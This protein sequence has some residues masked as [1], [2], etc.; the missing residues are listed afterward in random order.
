LG[1]TPEAGIVT[2]L[3]QT[4]TSDQHSYISYSR[5][6]PTFKTGGKSAKSGQYW[7]NRS[8]NNQ[9]DDCLAQS[10]AH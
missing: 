9:F 1:N 4:V 2:L 10:S 6:V 7:L 8:K 3:P 5:Y